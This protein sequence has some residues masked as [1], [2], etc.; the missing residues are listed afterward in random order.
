MQ[1][2]PYFNHIPIYVDTRYSYTDM[3]VCVCVV[4]APIVAH[5]QIRRQQQQQQP[6]GVSF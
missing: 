5:I 1:N 2:H 3:R 6:S 4:Q